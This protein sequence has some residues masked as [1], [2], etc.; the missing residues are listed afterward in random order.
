[1]PAAP[2]VTDCVPLVAT[3]PLQ[4]PDAVQLLAFAAFQVRLMIW[5]TVAVVGEALMLTTTAPVEVLPV[6]PML[7]VL[8]VDELLPPPPPPQAA[9]S[10]PMAAADSH[11]RD[12]ERNR[13]SGEEEACMVISPSF[14]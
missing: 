11:L 1:M 3:L 2:A 4:A 8:L 14:G 5:P 10:R 6:E 13:D 9:S 7:F 12:R